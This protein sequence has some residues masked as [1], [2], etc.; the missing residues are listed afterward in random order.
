MTA[1]PPTVIEAAL[2]GMT[3]PEANPHVPRTV[4]DI[5]ESGLACLDAGA[6]IIHNHNDEPNFGG[7]TRHSAEPYLA[8]W[9][10]LLQ[11]HPR[12]LLHPTTAGAT[13]DSTVQ[14]RQAHVIELHEAGVLGMGTCDAG[15]IA[16]AFP[17]DGGTAP[18]ARPE[19][20]GNSAADVEWILG[21]CRERD[22]PVHISVFEPGMLRLILAH[23]AAGS[24]PRAKIQLYL[25]GDRMLFGLPANP[26]GLNAYLEML[27]DT[28]LPW[29][30]AVFGGDVIGSG[31]ARLAIER[32]GH[33][34]VGLEDH[35][36]PPRT[37]RN[38]ELVGEAVGL[39]QA[40]GR[41]P[42]TPDEVPEILWGK[43]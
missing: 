11:R 6:S 5:V 16:L 4:D 3:M 8:A 34:R 22:V 14:E 1:H 39:A 35:H 33:V 43:L 15:T 19:T 40:G 38:E 29:M 2:N 24:L 37:P 9:R 13:P 41:R 25:G 32:G 26:S 18:T 23:H 12:L 21:W 20:F 30:V 10:R 42:A 36:A 31:L 17:G 28:G 27:E 7:A